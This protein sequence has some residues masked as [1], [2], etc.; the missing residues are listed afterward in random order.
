MEGV[1]TICGWHKQNGFVFLF[2]FVFAKKATD[3]SL[4]LLV[5]IVF[6][7]FFKVVN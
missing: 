6:D 4:L 2:Y 1:Q 5:I 7:A 3:F